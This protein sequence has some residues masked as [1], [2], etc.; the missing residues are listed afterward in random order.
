MNLESFLLLS[1]STLLLFWVIS[2]IINVCSTQEFRRLSTSRITA[3]KLAYNE[4]G[5]TGY[6][7][8]SNPFKSG[9]YVLSYYFIPQ[10]RMDAYKASIFCNYFHSLPP[11]GNTTLSFLLIYFYSTPVST[12]LPSY[13]IVDS[14]LTAPPLWPGI[15][16]WYITMFFSSIMLSLLPLFSL[17]F[18]SL[19]FWLVVK[20]VVPLMFWVLHWLIVWPS[21]PSWSALP[22]FHWLRCCSWSILL[23]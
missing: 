13:K 8:S 19:I 23:I 16:R 4:L 11:V 12:I 9:K 2:L 17:L 14:Y 3:T 1:S 10:D 5:S 6:W 15:W 20:L 7:Y 22:I 18:L 21:S